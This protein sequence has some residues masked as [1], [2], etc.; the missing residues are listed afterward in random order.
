MAVKDPH[1]GEQIPILALL[2]KIAENHANRSRERSAIVSGSIAMG[3]IELYM[4]RLKWEANRKGTS[5][6]RLET[7]LFLDMQKR[8]P[9]GGPRG[10]AKRLKLARLKIRGDLATLAKISERYPLGSRE[11]NALAM[12]ALALVRVSIDDKPLLWYHRVRSNLGKPL[13]ARQRKDMESR[14]IKPQ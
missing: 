8:K 3:T 12:I 14:G 4:G 2:E 5:R 6:G 9:R 10:D 13:T 11:L 1:F 7:N